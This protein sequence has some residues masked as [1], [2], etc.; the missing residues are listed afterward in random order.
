MVTGA[1]SSAHLEVARY[2]LKNG[3]CDPF[4]TGKGGAWEGFSSF[5]A[6][7][8]NMPQFALDSLEA[9]YKT[10]SAYSNTS[11]YDFSGIELDENHTSLAKL[12]AY[13]GQEG[14]V[15]PVEL[16]IHYG[17]K[18]LI[19]TPVIKKILEIRWETFGQKKFNFNFFV[20]AVYGTFF[21]LVA[22]LW[23]WK[24][25]KEGV[26]THCTV[27]ASILF[28]LTFVHINTEISQF[29]GIF[30]DSLFVVGIVL[31]LVFPVLLIIISIN[32]ALQMAPELAGATA[33]VLSILLPF[34]LMRLGLVLRQT[35]PFLVSLNKVLWDVLRVLACFTLPFGG[36]MVSV[37]IAYSQTIKVVASPTNMPSMFD[38]GW[39]EEINEPLLKVVW[40]G[41]YIIFHVA[42]VTF[43]AV[44]IA[45]VAN[46][47][48]SLQKNA[49]DEWLIIHA[50]FLAK[51][52]QSP[53]Q[54]K[55]YETALKIAEQSTFDQSS[56]LPISLDVVNNKL[57]N[58]SLAVAKIEASLTADTVSVASI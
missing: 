13:Q 26:P 23:P 58:L 51:L 6:S 3:G 54:L 12:R 48:N 18:E 49:L 33:I 27:L 43:V 45:V 41:T 50:K 47:F 39:V 29:Q 53:K 38:F 31:Q 8:I 10:S 42:I 56:N 15:Q 11:K 35:G 16:M 25:E 7:I 21:V 28:V 34:S 37:Y 17:R 1:T 32:P 20:S 24:L 55:R 40:Q 22:L 4:L 57:D 5:A 30:L 9:K 19:A 52:P 44:L 36:F 14:Y 2:L 46:S